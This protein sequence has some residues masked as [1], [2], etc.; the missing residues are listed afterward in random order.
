MNSTTSITQIL[1]E[2]NEKVKYRNK[3]QAAILELRFWAAD[4][5]WTG[6]EIKANKIS[7]IVDKMRRKLY[8]DSFYFFKKEFAR[9]YRCTWVGGK[10]KN[11]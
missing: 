8:T 3:I 4:E 9:E 5:F 2:R 10:N 7:K 11:E 6:S 1:E